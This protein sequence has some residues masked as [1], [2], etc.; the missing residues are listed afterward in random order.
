M[1]DNRSVDIFL[2]M[3][4]SKLPEERLPRLKEI[5][6][7]CSEYQWNIVRFMTFKEPDILL[8]VSFFA[9]FWGIDRFI[10]K[11]YKIGILK[12][13][14]VQL[15]V[16][17]EIACIFLFLYGYNSWGSICL[18]LLIIGLLWWI[19]DV[20]LIRKETKEYNYNLILKSLNY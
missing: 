1:Q 19:I 16:I 4:K 14:V 20:F 6:I 10:L 8:A 15:S 13:L 18:I 12:F 3:N 17:G 2:S 11:Q 5:L 7:N 9:G